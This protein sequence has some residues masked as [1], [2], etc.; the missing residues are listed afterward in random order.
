MQHVLLEIYFDVINLRLKISYI[1]AF[2]HK[3]RI[4]PGR[5]RGH[6]SEGA[7]APAQVPGLRA[8]EQ[9]G[10]GP[11]RAH[12]RPHPEHGVRAQSRQEPQKVIRR[13]IGGLFTLAGIFLK[14]LCQ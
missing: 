4:E 3:F 11:L 9:P 6:D 13:H 2:I 12:L 1:H 5:V 10:A 7:S 14:K 8:A